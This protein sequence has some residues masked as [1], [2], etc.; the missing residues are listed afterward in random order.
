[1]LINYFLDYVIFI[2]C[3]SFMWQPNNSLSSDSR[4]I[5]QP[6]PNDFR[7]AC[8]LMKELI[9]EDWITWWLRFAYTWG[10]WLLDLMRYTYGLHIMW[11]KIYFES[12]LQYSSYPKTQGPV[13]ETSCT[14]RWASTWR[15][16]T[17]LLM[18]LCMSYVI[19]MKVGIFIYP[20]D[21]I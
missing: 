1:M 8:N 21:W 17:W 3:F 10:V 5:L 13:W 6:K 9:P 7:Y 14:W 4:P 11:S 19:Y 2:V 12:P 16:E 20:W 15:W 18:N